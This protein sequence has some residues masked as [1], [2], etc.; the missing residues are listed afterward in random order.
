M[1]RNPHPFSSLTETELDA[2]LSRARDERTKA[3]AALFIGFRRWLGSALRRPFS[4]PH[5]AHVRTRALLPR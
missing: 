1:D 3:I 4:R 2:I 5:T